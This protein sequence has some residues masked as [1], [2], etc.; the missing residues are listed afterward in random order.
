MARQSA[1]KDQAISSAWTCYC[2]KPLIK[3]EWQRTDKNS[4]TQYLRQ[5]IKRAFSTFP[6][7][8]G[9]K[10]YKRGCFGQIGQG[11]G[12]EQ[13]CVYLPLAWNHE[14]MQAAC[15]RNRESRFLARRVGSKRSIPKLIMERGLSASEAGPFVPAPTDP[16]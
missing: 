13:N 12:T 15:P 16:N 10:K 6:T 4:A 5:S 14:M 1:L 9:T 3:T 11:G 7:R 2:R 8:L